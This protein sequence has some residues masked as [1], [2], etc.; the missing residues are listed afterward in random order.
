M[1]NYDTRLTI[2]RE[3]V[4][5]FIRNSVMQQLREIPSLPIGRKVKSFKI[6][7]A[8]SSPRNNQK[9]SSELVKL[10][11]IKS[12]PTINLD[13]FANRLL[14]KSLGFYAYNY[15]YPYQIVS[16]IEHKTSSSKRFWWHWL[17]FISSV[18]LFLPWLSYNSSQA[19]NLL[20]RAKIYLELN[21]QQTQEIPESGNVYLQDNQASHFNRAIRQAR[22]IEPNSP[23]Y[24]DAR[25]DLLRW[26]KVILDIA[27][28]RA[29]QGDLAGAIAAAKLIPQDEPS[30]DF[31][32]RQAKVS[33]EHWTKRANQQNLNEYSLEEAKKLISPRVASSYSQAIG[34]LRQISP[35][36]EEYQEAQKLIEEWSKEIYLIANYRA[37][38]GNFKQAI[39]AASLVPKDSLYYQGAENAMI[40][41]KQFLKL[42][43]NVDYP[44]P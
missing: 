1:S 4:L 36:T 13:I 28:G 22:T 39:E 25:E 15:L 37:A 38:R 8:N 6:K 24:E 27:R 12:T 3:P 14:T 9:N 44:S 19:R 11:N 42:Q 23:F 41:W 30:I 21:A 17:L 7:Q 31:V 16:Q 20:G 5:P 35:G 26:S 29:S 33:I 32:S 34:V 10:P 18:I 43:A 2:D 40:K